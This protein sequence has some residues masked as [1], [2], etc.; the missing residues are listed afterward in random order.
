MN[1][2]LELDKIINEIE[3]RKAGWTPK[4]LIHSCCAPCSSYVLEYLSNYFAITIY[5]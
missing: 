3:A 5:Y 4:L 2:Q 1:Y